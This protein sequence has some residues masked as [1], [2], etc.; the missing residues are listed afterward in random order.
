[1]EWLAGTQEPIS[2]RS[3]SPTENPAVLLVD[4]NELVSA[5]EGLTN[6]TLIGQQGQCVMQG[7]RC[8]SVEVSDEYILALHPI[9]Y[10]Q[11]ISITLHPEAQRITLP[12]IS[13]QLSNKTSNFRTKARTHI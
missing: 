11:T 4:R 6:R 12:K 10:L 1:M 3:T 13:F 5:K 9:H 2:D 7:R 8:L